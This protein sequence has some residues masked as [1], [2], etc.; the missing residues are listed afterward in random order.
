MPRLSVRFV[1]LMQDD[2]SGAE[3]PGGSFRFL[4]DGKPFSP[5]RK[6]EG[7][8]A[9]CGLEGE[10]WIVLIESPRYLP[11]VLRVE[12]SGL[13]L[14]NPV[15]TVRLM[16]RGETRFPDC[17]LLEGSGLPGA[18][19]YALCG[20]VP[21]LLLSEIREGRIF[22]QGYPVRPLVRLRFC[23]GSG[24]NRE[25][26]VITARDADG[27]CQIDRHLR[28]RH[29]RGEP[30]LRAYGAVC[31]LSGRFAIPVG[32]GMKDTLKTIETYDKEVEQW[33]CLLQTAPN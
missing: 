22:F 8:C 26:F 18:L 33:G 20:N 27:G 23:V 4:V 29:E 11:T 14:G 13:P 19:L 16:R 15:R 31:G 5:I 3:L 28:F 2:F 6:P 1:L 32:I 12:A 7:F 21:P 10:S 25:L 24:A 9:F 17:E 30:V